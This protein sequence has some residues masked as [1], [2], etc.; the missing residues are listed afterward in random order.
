V[1]AIPHQQRIL[2]DPAQVHAVAVGEPHAS[3]LSFV[4]WM[5]IPGAACLQGHSHKTSRTHA[6]LVADSDPLCVAA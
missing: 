5:M 1:V 2:Q 4:V 6:L 3:W